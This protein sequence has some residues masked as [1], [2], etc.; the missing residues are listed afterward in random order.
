MASHDDSQAPPRMTA[1]G[2]YEVLGRLG[3]GAMADVYRARDPGIGR[4]VAI[5]VLKP[6]YARN[7]E[8]GERF[9]RE[10][11]AA[12]AL[13]HPHIATVH[14][15]GEAGGSAYLAMELIEG[16]P[17]DAVI[18]A[19]GRLPPERVLLL[20]RQLADAL[21]YAHRAGVVH[22][23]VKPSNILLSEDGRTAKLLDFGVARLDGF[24]GGDADPAD[25]AKT[26]VGQLI[27]TPRYM[28]P[29]QALGLPIDG[30]ADLFSLGVVLYEMVTGAV[31]FPGASLATLA[32]QIAQDSPAPI[33]RSTAD[34]PPGLRFVID[35]LLCKKPE[36]RFT[37][38]EALVAALDREIAAGRD[39]E[40]TRRGL[41]LRLT[42]PLALAGVTALA[43][44]GS[45]WAI[46]GR[47]RVA[48]ERMA[49]VSGET[50]VTFV[51]GNAAVT[52]ADNAGLPADQQDWSALQAFATTAARDRGVRAIVV[53]DGAGV[54]R[55][56]SRPELVG[57]RY[58]A[59][60]GEVR[61]EGAGTPVTTAPDLGKGAGLRFVRPIR[62]AG[63]DFGTVDLVLR[64]DALDGALATSRALLAALSVV[65]TLAVLL[66]GYLSGAFVAGP[67]RRLREA[68][69]DAPAAG[70]ALRL[71]HGR[72][73]E[74]GAAFDAFNRAAAA[75]EPRLHGA[76]AEDGAALLATRV[77]DVARLAA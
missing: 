38:G 29:E 43:L 70:F 47:E 4:V 59:P 56:S 41:P 73:D 46:Q 15:V 25:L 68:L 75:M 27:G 16:R 44:G 64:R 77:A 5:K 24:G 60:A 31:A 28:S 45:V 6:E 36:A 66:V 62:Y 8:I 19:Q 37:N 39:V 55:A 1:I 51:T 11:R 23:D 53:A 17:L 72:R 3:E 58:A 32:I 35:K 69:D 65:V 76:P 22:R 71:P 40:P 33:D 26:Q 61:V 34:C 12:G 54:V 13:N 18:A 9:L 63:A 21:A 20:A 30:R 42:L 14:D 48:L 57:R 52:A 74:F 67:L 7:A 2:R 49:V 50:I 10:A